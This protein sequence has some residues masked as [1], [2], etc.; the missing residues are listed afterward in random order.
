MKPC[1]GATTIATV[2]LTAGLLTPPP[3][4]AQSTAP[5]I[6]R[7]S[8]GKPDFSGFWNIQYAPDMAQ[9]KEDQVPYT[10]AGRA[11]FQH[12][13]AK[14]DPTARCLYPGVPRIMSSP[15]PVQIL[16]TPEYVVMAFEYMRLWRVIPTD[17]RPHPKKTEPTYMGDNVG[18]WEGDTFVID[19]VGLL[20]G[21]KTW[22]DTA[23]HQHSDAM[24]V[25]ERVRR[26]AVDSLVLDFTLDD[27]EMYA[28]PW[29][30][31]RIWKPLPPPPGLPMLLEYLCTENNR[32]LQHLVTTKPAEK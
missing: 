1:F 27:P 20:G 3:A 7:T 14:D 31:Q 17:H 23:G 15:Y 24:H 12:H 9:G 32:D 19:T 2:L 29:T 21:D 4:A 8:D 26:T 28:K 13:D 22:L 10:A 18:W 11:A 30:S 6:P 25:V 5:S 16:Q